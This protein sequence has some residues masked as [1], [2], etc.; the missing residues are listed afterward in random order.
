VLAGPWHNLGTPAQLAEA[1]ALVQAQLQAQLQAPSQA[2]L[3]TR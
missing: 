1:Q 3:P 2:E